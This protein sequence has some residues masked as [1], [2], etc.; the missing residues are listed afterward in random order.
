MKIIF[1]TLMTSNIEWYTKYTTLFHTT[2]CDKYNYIY[3]KYTHLF[4]SSRWATWSKIPAIL[5]ALEKY[6]DC[7]YVFWCDADSI[8][9]VMDIPLET[10]ITGEDIIITQDTNVGE[11]S[12]L[13]PRPFDGGA[14]CTGNFFVKN[15]SATKKYFS[16]LY[17]DGRFLKFHFKHNYFH[18]QS[19][20]TLS[21]LHG[22]YKDICSIKLLDPYD[23]F[24]NNINQITHFYHAQGQNDPHMSKI[25]LQY[26]YEKHFGKK[27]E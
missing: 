7:D 19:A 18:E 17:N 24:T 15:N 6:P 13:Y 22:A 12:K 9:V 26:L 16:K 1:V 21:F 3:E 25:P 23:L 5:D 8:P 11:Y 4:D 20:L 27:A 2:Y 10:Y 14:P